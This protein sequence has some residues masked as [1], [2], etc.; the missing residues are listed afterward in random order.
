MTEFIK[1]GAVVNDGLCSK[2]LRGSLV[3]MTST[4]KD[5]SS[6]WHVH[7]YSCLERFWAYV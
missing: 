7:T 5:I 1:L 2:Q 4:F 3:F 6:G